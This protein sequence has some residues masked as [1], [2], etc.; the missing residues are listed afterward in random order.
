MNEIKQIPRYKFKNQ[1]KRRIEINAL[2]YLQNKRGSKGKEIEFKILEMSEYLLPYHGKLNIEEKREIFELR[3][4]MTN[5][6]YNFGNKE[7]PC[8]CGTMETMSHI[9]SCETLNEKKIRIDYDQI[10]IGNIENMKEIMKRMK[11]NLE[12]RNNI[13]SK[14]EFPRDPSDPLYCNQYGFG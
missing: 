14:E 4:R 11:T 9:Y 10:Y 12:I 6:P 1:I 13:K 8:V 7:E 5:I 2:E 3:N